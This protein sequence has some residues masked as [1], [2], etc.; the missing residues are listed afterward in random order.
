MIGEF[1]DFIARGN[2]IDLAVG[3]IMGG[4]FGKIVGSLVTDILTP[5]IGFLASGVDFKTLAVKLQP[6][7]L[8]GQEAAPAAINI[9]YGLFLDAVFQFLII[10][11]CI[12]LLVKGVNSLKK[13]QEA[14]PAEPPAQEKL[15]AE[16]RDLLKARG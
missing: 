16:I 14:A 12:F 6:P 7:Q 11:F 3:V 9:S 2:V 1:K 13:K 4:A 8:P 5:P 10:S 15:L